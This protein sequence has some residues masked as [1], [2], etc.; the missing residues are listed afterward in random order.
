MKKNAC[1]CCG[2]LTIDRKGWYEICPVCGWE[3]SGI[4]DD[5]PDE[6]VGGP[7]H[8]TLTEARA[9]FAKFGAAEERHRRRVREPLP[10]EEPQ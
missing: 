4:D 10:S 7:N 3:D 8:V 5:K 1:P 9:N 6:Y 2:F